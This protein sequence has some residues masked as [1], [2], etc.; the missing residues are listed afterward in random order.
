MAAASVVP[1]TAWWKGHLR[2]GRREAM[3]VVGEERGVGWRAGSGVGGVEMW[4]GVE[5]LG[6]VWLGRMSVNACGET[7]W[8]NALLYSY[9]KM[10]KGLPAE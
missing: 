2:R 3:I 5:G 7:S 1:R 8:A 10:T 4:G 6:V 9:A